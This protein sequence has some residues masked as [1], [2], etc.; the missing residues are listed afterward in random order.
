MDREKDS[1]IED[2]YLLAASVMSSHYLLTGQVLIAISPLPV[3]LGQLPGFL[4]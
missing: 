1:E 4:W 3:P 2:D